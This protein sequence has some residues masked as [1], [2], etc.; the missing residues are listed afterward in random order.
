MTN[1]PDFKGASQ[2]GIPVITPGEFLAW[3][4]EDNEQSESTA[5]GVCP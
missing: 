1:G 2:F 5:S 3:L 4:K